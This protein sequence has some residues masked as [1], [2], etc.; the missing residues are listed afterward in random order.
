MS[1]RPVPATTTLMRL[2]SW[3]AVLARGEA[4]EPSDP[5]ILVTKILLLTEPTP[6]F[7][8]YDYAVWRFDSTSVPIAPMLALTRGWYEF[9]VPVALPMG[10]T[11]RIDADT[12]DPLV[13]ALAGRREVHDLRPRPEREVF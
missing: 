13:F 7:S 4:W 8:P 10:S 9:P 12:D 1:D 5:G 6:L 2:A 11:I 3:S